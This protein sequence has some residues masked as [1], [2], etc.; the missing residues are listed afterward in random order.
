MSIFDFF[1]YIRKNKEKK[2]LYYSAKTVREET[3]DREEVKCSYSS[4]VCPC[5]CVPVV[6]K[7]ELC[8]NRKYPE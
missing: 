7:L 5:A 8:S 4:D 2:I 6:T 1:S 3:E